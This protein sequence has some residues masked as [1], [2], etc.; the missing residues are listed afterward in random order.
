[1][2]R[3][4]TK[5][6]RPKI[7]YSFNADDDLGSI[8]RAG[9]TH[10]LISYLQGVP[11]AE[12][13]RK[14]DECRRRGLKVIY[15]MVDLVDR[16]RR[17]G[18]EERTKR[19]V[20]LLRDH[21]ALAAWQTF[22]ET[23]LP[24][25]IQVA[26]Y[27][28]IKRWDPLHPV[29]VVVTNEY[30]PGSYRRTYTDDAQDVVMIDFYPY[31]RGYDG[32][33]YLRQ[34]I[35]ALRAAQR[36][37]VPILPIIQTSSSTHVP[38]SDDTLWP[39]PGGLE[40]Q[41]NM[42][43]R[44][45]ADAGVACWMWRGSRDYPFI[46]IADRD[47]P[48]YA[49]SETA[50]LLAR[51]PDGELPYQRP[52]VAAKVDLGAAGFIEVPAVRVGRPGV[53]VLKNSGF[54]RGLEEWIGYSEI[55]GLSERAHG[56]RRA[57]RLANAGMPRS[58]GVGQHTDLLVPPNATATASCYYRVLQETTLLQWMV[59]TSAFPRFGASAFLEGRERLAPGGWRRASISVTNETGSPQ[60]ITNVGVISNRFTGEALLDDFQL[61][62]A[63]EPG[64]YTDRK[65]AGVVG[66]QG[67][68]SRVLR[69]RFDVTR[70]SPIQ[71]V[72]SREG[73]RRA[74][75][76]AAMRKTTRR[77]PTAGWTVAGWCA[78]EEPPE[79]GEYAC[80]AALTRKTGTPLELRLRV[81]PG[82]SDR[83]GW[84]GAL[85]VAGAGAPLLRMPLALAPGQP[86][87]WSLSQVPSGLVALRAAAAGYRL[88]SGSSRLP[89]SR[90]M[91]QSV[92]LGS[93]ARGNHPLNGRVSGGRYVPE[94]LSL[95]EM[96]R[97]RALVGRSVAA[98]AK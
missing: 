76:P 31:K 48:A 11:D 44:L 62:L 37:P 25:E 83:N 35:P 38:T 2:L 82:Q 63:P 9:F 40:K 1:L 89:F 75:G 79:P 57:A 59:Q 29:I 8:R 58:V 43:W 54:E 80:L 60:R 70:S 81:D 42:W 56:G 65:P 64:L 14:L 90:S 69:L 71:S 95:K 66:S 67:Q 84:V 10:V 4:P 6:G 61:E 12:Q 78:P 17:S 96:E 34:S 98:R 16:D 92:W 51:I 52:G 30:A 91:V 68:A 94:A 21:P 49:L 47:A 36:R 97:L 50:A 87:F 5:G 7:A 28:K 15:R 93:D 88:Q 74:S 85:E 20:L 18:G 45:G 23:S 41:V 26:V 86:V 13:R 72:R 73:G 22:E 24:P 53:N 46:G 27:R 19:A 55:A 3:L 39:P 33:V 77:P 32:W